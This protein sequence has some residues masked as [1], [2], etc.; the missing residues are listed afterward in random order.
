[1]ANIDISV[2]DAGSISIELDQYE[3][4][5]LTVNSQVIPLNATEGYA[6]N[7]AGSGFIYFEATAALTVSNPGNTFVMTGIN[8]NY[9]C[10]IFYSAP[11]AP[12]VLYGVVGPVGSDFPS[13]PGPFVF[14]QGS[15]TGMFHMIHDN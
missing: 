4:T 7:Q 14:T 3:W 8:N 12:F 10:N 5:G 9:F 1:M 15:M 11:S 2:N 6:Y 13:L